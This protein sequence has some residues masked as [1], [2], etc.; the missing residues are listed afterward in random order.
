VSL[1]LFLLGFVDP[2]HPAFSAENAVSNA[3]LLL[4]H[5]LLTGDEIAQLLS[6]LTSG[7]AATGTPPLSAA[8]ATR[9]ASCFE[10]E[11]RV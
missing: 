2:V 4:C 7:T 3:V 6:Q 11:V 9:L 1:T 10:S 8:A 5:R